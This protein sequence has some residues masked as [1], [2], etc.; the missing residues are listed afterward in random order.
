MTKR[1]SNS[2]VL[3]VMHYATWLP[4]QKELLPRQMPINISSNEHFYSPGEMDFYSSYRLYKEGT[5]TI[6]QWLTATALRCGYETL[7]QK[8]KRKN[9][10]KNRNRALKAKGIDPSSGNSIVSTPSTSDTS[11]TTEPEANVQ[12]Q[13]QQVPQGESVDPPRQYTVSTKEL[14]MMAYFISEHFE[15]ISEFEGL[16]ATMKV[17]EDVIQKRQEVGKAW[18]KPDRTASASDERH[19]HFVVILQEVQQILTGVLR[20]LNLHQVGPAKESTAASL[21]ADERALNNIF[22]ALHLEEPA[23]VDQVIEEPQ[24]KAQPVTATASYE[25]EEEV[26]EE[27]VYFRIYCFFK[28]FQDM[29]HHLKESWLAYVS[30]TA[31]LAAVTITT[32]V[33]IGILQRAEVDLLEFLPKKFNITSYTQVSGLLYF[34]AAHTHGLDPNKA[35]DL[36]NIPAELE[37]VAEFMAMPVHM[38]LSSFIPVLNAGVG[39]PVMKPG[40]YGHIC[41]PEISLSWEEKIDQQKIMLLE[42]LPEICIANKVGQPPVVDE[43]TRGLLE[44]VKTHKISISLVLSC[45]IYLDIFDATLM[46]P[47]AHIG[48]AHKELQRT[49]LYATQILKSYTK[50]SENMLIDNWPK[51][52]DMII[53]RI[54]SEVETW[55]TKDVYS[56]LQ[57]QLFKANKLPTDAI[58]PYSLF[59]RHPLLCGVMLFRL[60][61]NLQELG[62][63]LVNAWGSLPSI[64]HLYNAVKH[65]S[66]DFPRWHDLEAVIDIHSKERIFIGEPPSDPEH[67]LKRFALVMGTSASMLA[68][69]RREGR[70]TRPVTASSR[71]PREMIGISAITKI[72]LPQYCD[73]GASPDITF[74]RI[75][76]LLRGSS[77]KELQAARD[78]PLLLIPFLTGLQEKVQ[79]DILALNIDYLALHMRC[80]KLLRN[81]HTVLDSD[82]KKFL[83]SPD[84]IEKESQLPFLVGYLF[85]IAC[86]SGLAAEH[87]GIAGRGVDVRSRT[88]LRAA[89]V[90][91]ELVLK[92]GDVEIKRVEVYCRGYDWL[93]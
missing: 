62:V 77:K 66:P 20:A 86:N 50:F 54:R 51:Q 43:I 13:T 22:S 78:S 42:L 14:P 68:P 25:L 67:Y 89:D 30:G 16:P 4:Q 7:K 8:K 87:L 52:N 92:E 48:M 64:L 60:N 21:S 45:Q 55:I 83:Q 2:H 19:Q 10:N 34:A 70:N 63:T 33:A 39:L 73:Q 9:K 61:L 90:V 24:K 91:K 36:L 41:G 72:F 75:Q 27:E 37:S 69:N 32:N 5:R 3:S 82:F 71:G 53:Q 65:E 40:F 85:T 59:S 12:P 29:R 46:H 18:E 11:S 88:L 44:M 80:Y 17:L 6:I 26:D 93:N 56:P 31:D 49:G 84:Y 74:H 58:Q 47:L 28:D 57:K 15:Q 23:D 35:K 38:L 79:M 1:I 81:I 76:E